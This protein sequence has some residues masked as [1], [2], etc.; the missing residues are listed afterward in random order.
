M[1][2]QAKVLFVFSKISRPEGSSKIGSFPP[3]HFSKVSII[4]GP[5]KLLLFEYLISGPKSYRDFRETGHLQIRP[6]AFELLQVHL[7]DN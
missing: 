2:F 5:G 3:V 7:S 1:I 4:N 6:H